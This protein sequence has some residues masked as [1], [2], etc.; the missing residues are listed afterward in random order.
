MDSY[1]EDMT[2]GIFATVEIPFE[3]KLA[4]AQIASFLSMCSLL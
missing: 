1:A 3:G 4:R 2:F